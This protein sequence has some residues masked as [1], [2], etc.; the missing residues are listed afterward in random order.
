MTHLPFTILSFP[1]SYDQSYLMRIQI[2][3]YTKVE[4]NPAI[5]NFLLTVLGCSGFFPAKQPAVFQLLLRQIK[6]NKNDDFIIIK[7]Q[8]SAVFFSH[9]TVANTQQTL[10]SIIS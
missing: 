6:P 2:H 3:F 10:Y 7:S 9:L 4:S 5:P 8:K 1:K